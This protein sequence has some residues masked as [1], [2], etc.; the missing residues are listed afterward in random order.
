MCLFI[1]G[2]K[3][4]E[5]D[6][7][8]ERYTTIITTTRDNRKQVE[9]HHDRHHNERQSKT[10]T[11][12]REKMTETYHSKHIPRHQVGPSQKSLGLVLPLTTLFLLLLSFFFLSLSLTIVV[13]L[14]ASVKS[15]FRSCCKASSFSNCPPLPLV[16]PLLPLKRNKLAC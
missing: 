1:V 10:S 16:F 11:N 14:S 4:D 12:A 9:I 6:D 5:R 3:N 2:S 15:R 13:G 7:K 8:T